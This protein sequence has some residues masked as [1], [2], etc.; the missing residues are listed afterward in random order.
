[1]LD[2]I[3]NYVQSLQRQ[4]EVNSKEASKS[5]WFMVV[6]G[7]QFSWFSFTEFV[8][9]VEF[10]FSLSVSFNEVGNCQSSDG[11]QH[12]GSSVKGGKFQ[13]FQ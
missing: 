10:F 9:V 3:I 2:E 8:L 4:V 7:C 1:M 13:S 11:Y 12:G 6:I 5:Q